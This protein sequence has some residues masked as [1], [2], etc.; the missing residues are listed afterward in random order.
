MLK[1]KS[2]IKKWAAELLKCEV[3][4]GDKNISQEEKKKCQQTIESVIAIYE[5]DPECLMYLIMELEKQTPAI[6]DK[7]R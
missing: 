3:R 2:R 6:L 5:R 4:L 1:Q 7:Y